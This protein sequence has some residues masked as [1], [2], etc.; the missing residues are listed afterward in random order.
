MMR[1]YPILVVED[2]DEDYEAVTRAFEKLNML[3]PIF[4]CVDGDDALDFLY[5]RGEY[6][7]APAPALILLDLN[8]PGTDGRTVLRQIKQ[9][10]TL[11]RIPTI[12]LTTSDDTRDINACYKAGANSYIVK[13]VDFER[14]LDAIQLLKEYWLGLVL[15]PRERFY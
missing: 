8:M 15:L 2:S 4:R 3:N 11:K 12:V 13:P 6:T 5:R 7:E 14:F 10:P 1:D 9:E